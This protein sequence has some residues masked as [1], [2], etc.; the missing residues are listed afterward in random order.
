LR[1]T[2]RNLGADLFPQFTY[3]NKE[4]LQIMSRLNFTMVHPV[5]PGDS[6]R[7]NGNETG[8]YEYFD[9]A[10]RLGLGVMYDM[11]HSMTIHLVKEEAP[12]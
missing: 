4:K 1:R 3:S 11:R 6:Y 2:K 10:E 5:P 8:I 7:L 9:E 12:C